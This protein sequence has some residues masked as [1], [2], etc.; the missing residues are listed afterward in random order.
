MP[1]KPSSAEPV[2]IW[3]E[4]ISFSLFIHTKSQRDQKKK[5]C[6]ETGD[7]WLMLLIQEMEQL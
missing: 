6:M 2:L 4:K 5:N 7:L 3:K 1:N